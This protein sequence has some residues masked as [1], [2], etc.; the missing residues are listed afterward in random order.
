[1]Q[2]QALKTVPSGSRYLCIA[3]VAVLVVLTVT[4]AHAG[5][6]ANAALARRFYVAFN[7]RDLDSLDKFMAPDIVDHNPAP[8]Q[9][10]GIA[11]V[12]TSLRGF[13]AL[14]SDIQARND[15][16]IAKGDYVT[17]YSTATGMHTGDLL[18]V[19]ATHKPFQIHTLDIWRV[20]D[21]K[22]AEGWHVE[23]LLG[24]LTQV[25]ALPRTDGS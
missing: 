20:K 23:E 7:A 11:G 8:G 15:L 12:K 9:A 1:M 16:V 25:G 22:L 6:A 2:Q 3:L 24:I 21:G 5:E 17:V 18:G 14:S 10:G 13:F 19:K 4:S